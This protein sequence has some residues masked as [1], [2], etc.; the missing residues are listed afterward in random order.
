M[1][2]AIPMAAVVLLAFEPAWLALSRD[3]RGRWAEKVGEVAARHPNVAMDWFDADA[4]AGRYT[5]FVICR[6]E[7][8]AAYH[9]L[10]EELRDLEIF[11]RPFVRIVDVVMGLERG[12][13]V[14][15]AH[16]AA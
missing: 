12:Y 10:W 14:Y 4:L 8:I 5:D 6:F 16:A 15:E 11:S 2:P 13:E 1:K 9:F 7:E 3:E